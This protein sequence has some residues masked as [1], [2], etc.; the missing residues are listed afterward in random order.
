MIKAGT[1]VEIESLVLKC[2]DRASNI[3]EDT[4]NTPLKMWVK[5]FTL[6]NCELGDIVEIETIIGRKEKGKVVKEK[7]NYTHSFGDYV[8]ELAYIGK[9]AKCCLN[10]KR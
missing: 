10:N 8:E 6:E 7:P 4:K 5:G 9:Q 3:P 2:E 1:W